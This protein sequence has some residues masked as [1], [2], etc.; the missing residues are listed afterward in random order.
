MPSASIRSRRA[1]TLDGPNRSPALD[2]HKGIDLRGGDGIEFRIER[3]GA[4][5]AL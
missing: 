2:M 3:R 5:V 1:Q 4:G